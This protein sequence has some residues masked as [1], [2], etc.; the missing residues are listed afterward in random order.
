MGPAESFYMDSLF[1]K[2]LE[3]V[4]DELMSRII[5]NFAALPSAKKSSS[6]PVL[7]VLEVGAGTG[8]LI[9][10]CFQVDDSTN[11]IYEIRDG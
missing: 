8:N 6:K 4:G 2:R 1:Q 11:T 10:T 7:R 5:N 3:L 9:E